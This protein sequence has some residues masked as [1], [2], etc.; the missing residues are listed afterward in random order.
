MSVKINIYHSSWRELTKGQ[1]TIEVSGDT[2]GQCLNHLVK[3]FPAL[4]KEIFD[5]DG[6]LLNYLSIFV[7]REIAFPEELT[8]PVK[9]GDELDIIP[10]I[11]GG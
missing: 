7:N 9:D 3:Q 10:I 2:T 1:T 6:K 11:G 4:E 8:K 5:K